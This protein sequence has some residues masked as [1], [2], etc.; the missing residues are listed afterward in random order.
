MSHH[1]IR[2]RVSSLM[3]QSQYQDAL[4][5]LRAELHRDALDALLHVAIATCLAELGGEAEARDALESALS[6][7]QSVQT[8]IEDDPRLGF[9]RS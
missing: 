2:Q 5:L 3:A 9:W 6:L 4:E 7:D 8:A 1:D